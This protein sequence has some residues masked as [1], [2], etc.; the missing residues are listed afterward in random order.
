[1][2]EDTQLK[3]GGKERREAARLQ[4]A[5]YGVQ[6]AYGEERQAVSRVREAEKESKAVRYNQA[7]CRQYLAAGETAGTGET[8][9]EVMRTV[10]A[11]VKGVLRAFSG[12]FRSRTG[13]YPLP[14]GKGLLSVH[15]GRK[16]HRGMTVYLSSFPGI[17][18][19]NL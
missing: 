10:R 17:Y 4:N 19:L 2:G 13:K 9:R 11:G 7:E 16:R 12:R 1:M 8:D 6:G 5:A 14:P 18:P 15:K 3:A